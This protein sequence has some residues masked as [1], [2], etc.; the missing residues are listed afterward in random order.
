M[1]GYIFFTQAYIFF[2]IKRS[3]REKFWERE[4][5]I[6]ILTKKVREILGPRKNKLC[7]FSGD[8]YLALILL[9]ILSLGEFLLWNW[10]AILFDECVDLALN[11]LN[12]KPG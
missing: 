11:S 5:K 4:K 10:V 2:S 1:H 6:I 9:N 3:W 8:S 7:S 12:K